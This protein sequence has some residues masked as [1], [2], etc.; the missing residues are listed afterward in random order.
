MP[1]PRRFHAVTLLARRVAA[2]L[3]AALSLAGIA[4]RAN[5]AEPAA[6][7]GSTAYWR[8]TAQ[9]ASGPAEGFALL[10]SGQLLH[11][12]HKDSCQ[13][14]DATSELW[15]PAELPGPDDEICVRT[16]P[17]DDG[18]A[19]LVD[20]ETTA[21]QPSS[22][23]IWSKAGVS[24]L[25]L[26]AIGWTDESLFI[27][28][29]GGRVL[30]AQANTE[31][32][33]TRFFTLQLTPDKETAA[34]RS[35]QAFGPVLA[36]K[37]LAFARLPDGRLL[38][39]VAGSS[40]APT[41]IVQLDLASGQASPLWPPRPTG[42]E[43][44]DAAPAIVQLLPLPRTKS[45]VLLLS[46]ATAE[47][48]AR[49]LDID[50]GSVTALTV[51]GVGDE[52]GRSF[53]EYVV[54]TVGE[55]VILFRDT[56]SFRLNLARYEF[57]PLSAEART[58]GPVSRVF[59]FN[60]EA[61]IFN[62]N[63][64]PIATR[65]WVRGAPDPAAPC[66]G[67]F[68]LMT[69]LTNPDRD[70]TSLISSLPALAGPACVAALRAGALSAQPQLRTEMVLALNGDDAPARYWRKVA[71]TAFGCALRVPELL[72]TIAQQLAH[73]EAPLRGACK[74][75]FIDAAPKLLPGGG[76][77]LLD[78]ALHSNR[79][80]DETLYAL[81]GSDRLYLQ[82]APL[83]RAVF[84]R[85]NSQEDFLALHAAVCRRGGMS[86]LELA[87]AC[88]ELTFEGLLDHQRDREH[89]NRDWLY[90]LLVLLLAIG[91]G[92][93]VVKAPAASAHALGRFFTVLACALF[94]G[95]IG[96]AVSM[97]S[98]FGD[99]FI[100]LSSIFALFVAVPLAA[101]GGYVG[102]VISGRRDR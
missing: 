39:S 5:A 63:R 90:G 80:S 44:P 73:F 95:G 91:L 8:A 98:G 64:F 61:L 45:E 96:Y 79:L 99:G 48:A 20:C 19:L 3:G 27:P 47:P 42:N 68:S 72:P 86:P 34:A 82:A 15:A 60:D 52:S 89:A 13:L 92:V 17:L 23:A 50:S 4:R 35:W 25:E 69:T 55:D 81:Q 24:S 26:D 62:S 58:L 51:T 14:W 29:P 57:E 87:A 1:Q 28:L 93:M 78:E 38:L 94:P 77:A 22:A 40:A 76:S 12:K 43:P 102:L 85:G 88:A 84:Q 67:V 16:V 10:S 53:P 18:R 37:V 97:A 6:A 65:L 54:S 71:V 30:L 21:D 7:A 9:P 49:V 70:A 11:C 33:G 36:G 66:R 74:A 31:P 56:R 100:N 2:L 41:Q 101:L 46:H 32:A 59:P 75:A 83:L